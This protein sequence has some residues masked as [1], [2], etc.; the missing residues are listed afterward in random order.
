MVVLVGEGG[1]CPLARMVLGEEGGLCPS[2]GVVVVLVGWVGVVSGVVVVVEAEVGGLLSLIPVV[3]KGWVASGIV[4]VVVVSWLLVGWS[5]LVWGVVGVGG[6]CDH[7]SI[8]VGGGGG[9]KLSPQSWS[10]TGYFNLVF[11]VFLL[12]L[13]GGDVVILVWVV[14]AWSPP[15]FLD[16]DKTSPLSMLMAPLTSCALITRVLS[17]S[18]SLTLFSILDWSP[19]SSSTIVGW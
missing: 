13:V 2:T 1:L 16:G 7:I 12:E 14:V 5:L 11:L 8:G 4:G 9:S 17:S 19:S 3:L 18:H 10:S 15:L 6:V